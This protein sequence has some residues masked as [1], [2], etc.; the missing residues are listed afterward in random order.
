MPI[1]YIAEPILEIDG[2]AAT[3]SLIEDILEISVEESLHK[4]GTFTIVINNDY[5]P[6]RSQDQTWKHASLF[7]IGKSIKIGFTSSTSQAREFA[8]GKKDY[9]LEGEITGMEYHFTSDSQ[10]PMI[11]RG[12]DVSHRLTRG[13]YNRSFQNMTDTDIVKKIAGEVG[14]ST[15]TI[16]NTGGPYGY[17]DIGG[18]NGYI[19]QQ[20]QT[21][22]EFLRERANRNGFELFVK[23]GKLN[24]RKPKVEE[25]LE[26]EWLKDIHSFE[27]RVSSDEQVSEVEVR[28]WD[29]SQKRSIVETAR[30]GRVFTKTKH[31]EGVKTS[32]SF[33]GQPPTPKMIVVDKPVSN[34]S[35]AQNIAQAL[36]DELAGQFVQADGKAEGNPKIRTGTLVKVKDMGNCSGEYYVTSCCHLYQERVYTTEFSVRGSRGDGGV[37]SVMSYS[38]A[39]KAAQ[40]LL[41]GLVT[42]NKDPNGWGRVRVKFPAFTEDDT[43]YWARVVAT[44]A[45]A[46]R[47]FDCLPEINDEVMVAFEHGDMQ[48]PYVIGG[49]FNGKDNPPEKVD[50][51]VV[52]GKKRLRTFK[53]RTGHKLQ[54]VEEDKGSSKKGISLDTVAGH[55]VQMN[56]TDKFV[57]VNTNGGHKVRLDDQNKKILIQTSGGNKCEMSDS[58]DKITI[59][60]NQKIEITAPMGITLTVG[61]NT[62]EMSSTG[63]KIQASGTMD[64]QGVTT[65]VKGTVAANMEGATTSVKGTAMVQV[66][67][68]LVKIN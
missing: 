17:G 2:Q 64:I 47:G 33:K 3:A 13:R 51:S 42:D 32:K 18:G 37:G 52:G 68:A 4:P 16:D 53:T 54:F 43:S 31:G 6:G 10:A 19:F 66:Q 57:E 21:N 12:Y 58:G 29:Y 61:G 26:L 67:G 55:H 9:I 49:V 5:F 30:N 56:D 35:E 65:T 44:G 50:D 36:C 24:F 22:L 8:E 38:L 20:N 60:A 41:V 1:T 15:G 28:G 40:N 45:G 48:R 34:G 11:I 25:S 63:I 39:T 7:E 23:N 14:I 62:I 46:N 59:S 27:V